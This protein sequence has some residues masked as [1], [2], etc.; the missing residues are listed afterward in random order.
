[1]AASTRAISVLTRLS[2]VLVL[3][4]ERSGGRFGQER[5]ERVAGELHRLE[6][7]RAGVRELRARKDTVQG[8]IIAHR[9]G[10]E[11]VVVTPRT[12]ER[13]P[14]V[15]AAHRVDRVLERQVPQVI[16]T[17]SVSAGEGQKPGRHDPLG[18]LV[19]RPARGQKVAGDLLTHELVV[20]LVGVER[21]DDVIAIQI[22]FGNRIVGVVAARVG[23]SRDIHPIAAPALAVMRRGEQI[24]DQVGKRVRRFVGQKCVDL[25]GCRGEADQV[26]IGS[27][28]Q[29]PLVGRRRGREAVRVESRVNEA[30]DRIGRPAARIGG[31]ID[32][33]DRAKSPMFLVPLGCR[34]RPHV[35]RPDGPLAD[36]P[37]EVG[38]DRV[39]KLL[40]G[41]HLELVVGVAQG[42][43]E[44]A[45]FR[46][47]RHDCGARLAPF[48]QRLAAIDAEVVVPSSG[49]R[50]I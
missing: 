44:Q 29:G 3:L 6:L 16:R 23:I 48:E 39:G 30:I 49:R 15:R 43:D 36:P 26:E 21:V 4:L 37:L 13:D 12:A 38:D 34:H 50:G 28:Q 31:R 46:M 5:D 45:F 8:V 33:V 9:H 20:R 22:R 18:I 10:V 42:A 24:L 25:R 47:P 32:F 14:Q 7:F 19:G 27:A 1:M 40:L 41:W 11:L 35:F 2:F 17:R